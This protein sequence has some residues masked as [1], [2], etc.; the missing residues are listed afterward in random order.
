[1]NTKKVLLFWGLIIGL[2]T[3]GCVHKVTSKIFHTMVTRHI[4]FTIQNTVVIQQAESRKKGIL[5][6][7]TIQNMAVIPP[8]EL[9][10][11]GIHITAMTANTV[12]IQWDG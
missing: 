5:I 10:R 3:I 2:I 9:R 4:I 8:E 7:S 6:T 12:D 1:M 11:R